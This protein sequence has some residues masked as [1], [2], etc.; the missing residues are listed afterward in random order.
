M[1]RRKTGSAD[2]P[3]LDYSTAPKRSTTRP[4][5][6]AKQP[7]WLIPA[8]IGAGAIALLTGVVVYLSGAGDG[9]GK[10]ANPQTALLAGSNRETRPNQSAKSSD[11]P[12]AGTS[13]SSPK[14]TGIA[15]TVAEEN[16]A[17]FGFPTQCC[18][19]ASDSEA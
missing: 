5:K 13:Q 19:G 6:R 9:K 12:A 10:P 17:R 14:P 18:P 8:G 15:S 11:K 1:S 3:F 16:G 4:A 7:A 2:L